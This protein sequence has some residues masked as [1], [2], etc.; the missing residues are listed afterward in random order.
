VGDLPDVM[1]FVSS[2]T[3][4]L[5]RRSSTGAQWGDWV[6]SGGTWHQ[7]TE[8]ILNYMRGQDDDVDE[9]TEAQAREGYPD[10]F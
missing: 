6:F 8:T 9:V 5:L 7:P 2:R 3:G 1:Y 10:A 4:V